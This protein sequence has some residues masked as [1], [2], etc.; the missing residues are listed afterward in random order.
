[1]RLILQYTG[2]THSVQTYV[3]TTIQ[4]TCKCTTSQI[5]CDRRESPFWLRTFS[6]IFSHKYLFIGRLT[7]P[8]FHNSNII[9]HHRS[10]NLSKYTVDSKSRRSDT[11]TS[12]GATN[13]TKTLHS[14]FNQRLKKTPR[15]C[16]LCERKLYLIYL[17]SL[18]HVNLI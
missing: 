17:F 13:T 18:Q 15:V 12:I 10:L 6:V 16:H 14:T 9:H 8:T 11:S 3:S 4:A 7:T 5:N 1:M 2:S